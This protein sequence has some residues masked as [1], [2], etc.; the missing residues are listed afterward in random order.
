MYN[1]VNQLHLKAIYTTFA[2]KV[3]LFNISVDIVTDCM[4]NIIINWQR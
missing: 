3:L 2:Y 1:I 4:L